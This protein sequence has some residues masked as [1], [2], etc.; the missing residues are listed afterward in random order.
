MTF[1][2]TQYILWLNEI[3]KKDV[4]LVG[5]KNGSLGEM[6]SCLREKGVNVPNGFAL[7][8]NSYWH[9]LKFNQIGGKLDRKSVV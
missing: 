8:A 3:T 5:G 1:K 7:T 6:Y 2:I 4:A 9:F